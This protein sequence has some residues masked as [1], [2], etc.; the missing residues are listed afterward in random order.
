MPRSSLAAILGQ[1]IRHYRRL[2][3]LTQEALADRLGVS[4][5]HVSYI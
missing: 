4:L 5:R 2:R 3:G 1:Q